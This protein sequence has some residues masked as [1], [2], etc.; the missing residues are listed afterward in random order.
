MNL[1]EWHLLALEVGGEHLDLAL[2][3]LAADLADDS[4]ERRAP[5]SGRSSRSDE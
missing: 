2:G 4:D 3:G 1:R 5:L